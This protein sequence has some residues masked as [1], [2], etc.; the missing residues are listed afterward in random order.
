MGVKRNFIALISILLVLSLVA[1]VSAGSGGASGGGGAITDTTPPGINFIFPEDNL[2]VTEEL[3]SDVTILLTESWKVE[4]IP[5]KLE[6]T[7]NDAPDSIVEG[8][9]IR[10]IT[11]FIGEEEL[12][13][14]AD[15]VW[16]VAGKDYGYG[17]QQFLFFD[18]KD[19]KN[20]IVKYSENDDDV[21]ADFLY[22]KNSGNIARYKLEFFSVAK[23]KI[24]DADGTPT[25]DG[26]IYPDFQD[27]VLTIFNKEYTVT[28]AVRPTNEGTGSIQLDLIEKSVTDN[29]LV[30]ESKEYFV[31]DKKYN[32]EVISISDNKAQLDINGEV[33]EP[34]FENIY[35]LNGGINILVDAVWLGEPGVSIIL[36]TNKIVLRD[37]NVMDQISS[38]NLEVNGEPIDGT[39]I[40]ITGAV[41]G[42]FFTIATIEVN[43]T[44]EDDY[45]VGIGE[46]LSDVIESQGEEEKVLMNGLFDI[47]YQGLTEEDTHEIMLKT[48]SDRRY[49]LVW[50]DGD[51]NMV[52]MPV[53]YAEAEYDLSLGQ[54]SWQTNSRTNQKR[55][56]LEES[57]PIFKDDFF[58]VTGGTPED[59]TAKSYLLSYQGA[60]KV[61]KTS[62]K[63]KF[64]NH[65][66]GETLEYSV[67]N[68]NPRATIE[69]GGF[70]FAVENASD[71]ESDDFQIFVDLDVTSKD[72]VEKEEVADPISSHLLEGESGVYYLGEKEYLVTL[73]YLDNTK[74]KFTVND[75]KITIEFA[76]PEATDESEIVESDTSEDESIPNI[77]D[78]EGELVLGY[79][80]TLNDENIITVYEIIYQNY[81]GGIH[82]AS[83]TLTENQ[84]IG[85]YG[86]LGI[87]EEK[88][89]IVDSYGSQWSFDWNV[90]SAATVE[91]LD[92]VTITQTTPYKEDYDYGDEKPSDITLD[93]TATAGPKVTADLSGL[94]LLTP[95]GEQTINYGYT[96]LGAFVTF[97]TPASSP[98]LF[99]MEYPENQKLPQVYITGI[100]GTTIKQGLELQVSTDENAVCYYDVYP[101]PSVELVTFE[102]NGKM[103]F[104]GGT[105]HSQNL[106]DLG[107]EYEY[108]IAVECTDGSGNSNMELIN[109]HF[110]SD[111]EEAE[112]EDLDG[113]LCPS[114]SE[115]IVVH[116]IDLEDQ[117]AVAD[118]TYENGWNFSF[119]VTVPENESNFTMWIDDWTNEDTNTT[120]QTEGNVKLVYNEE[121]YSVGSTHDYSGSE[122]FTA[123]DKYPSCSGRQVEFDLMVKIPEGTDYGH[124]FT[125][126]G[127]RSLPEELEG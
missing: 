30:G 85:G 86:H 27:T 42:G 7:N 112:E 60:D 3:L 50:Y 32:L 10:D 57:I 6:M 39:E 19:K 93:I 51:N 79:S 49:E 52:E 69:L 47:E 110:S 72:S 102:Q 63:I 36:G 17:Y 41:Y 24:T 15:N 53:A 20:E 9:T 46:K 107:N 23:S 66:T 45:W 127:I 11:V 114:Y 108:Q 103:E 28:S 98:E 59:G 29:L 76:N 61:T 91:D 13:V 81:A 99:T 35:T 44:A 82:S 122:S 65:G 75:Q 74:A 89:S 2:V 125:S 62:P 123:V 14:L 113:F 77:Q 87:G 58:I 48:S 18:S 96:S 56:I 55:L 100:T 121:N 43:M 120:L 37:N 95:D 106:F 90:D 26:D 105:F 70:S 38:D 25:P 92:S 78:S 1:I 71:V 40:I 118:N 83:F 54:E 21:T 88:V 34:H 80:Y 84:F 33:I 119:L 97:E 68:D 117:N 22:F 116:N 31:N 12:S 67:G 5:K 109:F 124:Y 111:E 8:E 101:F 126:Y 73:S 64:K 16:N 4:K 115:G 104:T 94:V